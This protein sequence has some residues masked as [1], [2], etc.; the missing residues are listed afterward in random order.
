MKVLELTG[1]ERAY[2][3]GVDVLRGVDLSLEPGEVVGLLGKNGAGKTTLLNITMGLMDPHRGEVHLF[4]MQHG[5]ESPTI[6]RRVGYVSED[7]I[8]P[9]FMNV[10]DILAI[11]RGLFPTWDRDLERQLTERFALPQRAKVGELSKGQARQVAILCA[12]AHR[13][14]LLILDEPAGGLDPAAR[15]EFLEVAIE[16]LMSSGSTILFSSHHMADVERIAQRVVLL[17]EGQVFFDRELDKL[18][19]TLSLAVLAPQE[20]VDLCR[21][22]AIKGCSSARE[23]AGALRAVFAEEPDLLQMRLEQE[24]GI[25]SIATS[26][27]GLEDLFIETVEG[28]V[29]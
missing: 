13:P 7:Q 4:G 1:I 27:L 26:R 6:K 5:D 20:G 12:V 23:S 10:A 15:R 11:H 8:L 14:E 3:P 21:V 24:L 9:E 2:L 19:E 25:G 29:R 18:R 17:H 22:R 16:S 28:G